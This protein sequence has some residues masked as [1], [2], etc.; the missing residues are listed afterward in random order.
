MPNLSAVNATAVNAAATAASEILALPLRQRVQTHIALPLR[1]R[2]QVRVE[3]MLLQLR[4]RVAT[5]GQL[6]LPLRQR[7]RYPTA[8]LSLQLRQRVASAAVL[9][10]QLRQRARASSGLFDGPVVQRITPVVMLA[11]V[12][13]SAR[14]TGPCEI[15]REE[16]QAAVATFSL[17]PFAGPVDLVTWLGAAVQIAV[18]IDDGPAEVLFRGTVSDPSYDPRLRVTT[19]RCTDDLQRRLDALPLVLVDIIAGGYW[20]PAVFASDATGWQRAQDRLSTTPEALDIS[21]QGALR[22]TPWLAKTTPDWTFGTAN[23]ID[24]SLRAEPGPFRE[25]LNRVQLQVEVRYQRRL[26]RERTYSWTYPGGFAAYIQDSSSLP[27]EDAIRSA[28]QGA[29]WKVLYENFVRLPPS[30][31][32]FGL[33]WVH[34]PDREP[35]L[36]TEALITAAQRWTETIT[37]TY[38]IDVQAPASI[39]RFG[40]QLQTDYVSY[41]PDAPQV[42]WQADTLAPR[43]GGI[44]GST[45]LGGASLAPNGDRYFDDIDPAQASAAIVT[46]LARAQTTILAAHRSNTAEIAV[47]LLPAVDLTHTARIQTAAVVAQGKVRQVVH[48]LS[49]SGEGEATTTVRVAVSQA[50]DVAVVASPMAAPPRL[51]TAPTDGA[52]PPLGVGDTQT[53]LGGRAYS[54]QPQDA[55][56]TGW[57]GNYGLKIPWNAPTYDEGFTVDWGDIGREPVQATRELPQIVAIPHELLEISA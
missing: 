50:A 53:H 2:A 27:T 54:P 30:G 4:Q 11:G 14:L 43:T 28:A 41:A 1:Q 24:G 7:A 3:V 44:G 55:A 12:D 9:A 40:E 35:F 26:H 57:V 38:K 20:S 13:V 18:R 56:W 5:P 42:V 32:Y 8:V 17:L 16:S 36:V 52:P 47:P 34:N 29:G 6:A 37:E 23:I 19:F 48:R 15:D 25:Q 49:L 46:A 51:A 22:S 33:P 21:P 10:L 45:D 31:V 39:A